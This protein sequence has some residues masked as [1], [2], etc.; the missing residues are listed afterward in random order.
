MIENTDTAEQAKKELVTVTEF[1]GEGLSRHETDMGK[2]KFKRIVADYSGKKEYSQSVNLGTPEETYNKQPREIERPDG[3]KVQRKTMHE[4][5]DGGS[6]STWV[7]SDGVTRVELEDGN[8]RIKTTTTEQSLVQETIANL[9][10]TRSNAWNP[11]IEGEDKFFEVARNLPYS[12]HFVEKLS[13]T[14]ADEGEKKTDRLLHASNDRWLGEHRDTYKNTMVT[15]DNGVVRYGSGEH[16]IM[17]GYVPP[18]EVV[19]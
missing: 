11:L 19:K 16:G 1:A 4:R 6:R 14:T 3:T 10:E 15:S 12:A 2:E 8:L 9:G 18:M 5:W 13:V 17:L 7:D